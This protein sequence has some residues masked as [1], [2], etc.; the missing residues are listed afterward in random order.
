MTAHAGDGLTAQA[1]SAQQPAGR[2]LH[3]VLHEAVQTLQAAGVEGAALDAAILLETAAGLSRLERVMQPEFALSVSAQQQFKTL[4]EAR[5]AGQPV[6]YLTGRREFWGLEFE[7]T[8]DVLIPRPDS[9]TLVATLLALLPK[10]TADG[11]DVAFKRADVGTGSGC[12]LLSV[13]HEFPA[14][15]GVGLDCSAAALAVAQRNAQ[16]LGLEGRAQFVRSNLLVPL[17]EEEESVREVDI[18]ISNPPYVRRGDITTLSRDVQNEPHLALDGGEDGLDAYRALVPQAAEKL[19]SGGLLLLEIGA[20]QRQ[21]VL[22]LLNNSNWMDATC[23]QDLA[24]RDR[25]I[26]AVR[27]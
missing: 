5:A 8:P 18:I 14:A 22:E 12:L 1:G 20:D 17:E 26:A 6:A 27:A 25:V 23:Y 19:G 7:I 3:A 21:D 2:P 24:S 9:E 15:S 16:A 13:L 11:A 10:H 4:V